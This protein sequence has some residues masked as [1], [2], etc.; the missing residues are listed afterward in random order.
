MWC[1]T[2]LKSV[3]GVGS[4][5]SYRLKVIIEGGR[6]D[7]PGSRASLIFERET[8]HASGSQARTRRPFLFRLLSSFSQI[9]YVYSF[10][11]LVLSFRRFFCSM[12][13][14]FNRT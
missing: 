13:P 14:T 12:L 3:T 6:I 10:I 9:G 8:S 1:V 4:S 11:S 2:S 7:T 5:S